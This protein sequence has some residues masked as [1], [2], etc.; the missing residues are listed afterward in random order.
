MSSIHHHASLGL[1]AEPQDRITARSGYLPLMG[2]PDSAAAGLL[3]SPLHDGHPYAPGMTSTTQSDANEP[4]LPPA[5]PFDDFAQEVYL[6]EIQRRCGRG[7]R[8][9]RRLGKALAILTQPNTDG[10]PA[11]SPQEH[12]RVH[13]NA[14][15]FAEAVVSEAAMVA[16]LLWPDTR[17]GPG[18]TRAACKRREAYANQR[19]ATLRQLLGVEDDSPIRAKALR[20]SIQHFDERLDAVTMDPPRIILRGNI[21]PIDMISGIQGL[22]DMHLH[23]F[24]PADGRYT[25]LGDSVS[26]PDVSE[27]L[28]TILLRAATALQ[29]SNERPWPP[30]GQ[31]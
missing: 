4:E 11:L 1:A 15:D 29:Q 16:Q 22:E 8:A 3:S 9:A 28:Q 6:E 13:E 21:G 31:P 10:G 30:P 25:V 19:G 26:I 17:K 5:L 7:L 14:F 18:E 24:N 27:E 20:N 12:Q 23:H 2:Y